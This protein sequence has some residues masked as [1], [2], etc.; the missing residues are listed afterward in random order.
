MNTVTKSNQTEL[1]KEGQF[2][3]RAISSLMLLGTIALSSGLFFFA[4]LYPDQVKELAGLGYLG[5]FVVSLVSSATIILPV[6]GVLVAFSLAAALNPVLVALAGSTGGIIGEITGYMAGYGGHGIAHGNRMH[7][8][9]GGWM[10]RWGTW[11]ILL[12]AAVPLLPFDIAGVV[13]GALRFPLWKFLVIGWLGKSIK[14]VAVVFGMAWGWEA[15]LRFL[16]W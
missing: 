6:P 7:I 15:L 14:F 12:F 9:A 5:V 3:K 13:A 16:G 4:R 8:Q 2:R 11:T 10:R 1:K